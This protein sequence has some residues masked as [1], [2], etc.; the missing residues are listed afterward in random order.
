MF[1]TLGI[2]DKKAAVFI[3]GGV[4]VLDFAN[5]NVIKIESLPR[6]RVDAIAG[7]GLRYANGHETGRVVSV[8]RRPTEAIPFRRISQQATPNYW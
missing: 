4:R 2:V 1:F 3:F 8:E 6:N 7:E 5:L